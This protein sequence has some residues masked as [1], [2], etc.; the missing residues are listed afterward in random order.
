MGG[1]MTQFWRGCF[2]TMILAAGSAACSRNYTPADD[3]SQPPVSAATAEAGAPS[4]L[5]FTAP[6]EWVV[7]RPSS[8]MRKGQYRLSRAQ[9]DPEDAELVVF[10]F[11]GQGGSVQA[12]IDRW[13]GQFT[14]PDG[15]PATDI[16]RV[17]RQESQGVPLTVV[18]VSGTYRGAAGPMMTP[19]DP[20]ANF[21]MIAAVA[22]SPSGPWFFKLTG[23]AKTV[24]RWEESFHSFLN[25]IEPSR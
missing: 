9:A 23:P 19:A 16:A 10:F 25:T 20:K 11:E 12:N 3:E 24:A 2:L 8:P 17:S 7:E 21:R 13:V 1:A 15:S 22:E 5:K 4:G 18:D 6:A 14:K